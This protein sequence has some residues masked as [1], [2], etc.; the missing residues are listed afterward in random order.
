MLLLKFVEIGIGSANY[1]HYKKLGYKIPMHYNKLKKKYQFI[2]GAK[3]KVKIED[4]LISRVYVDVK[5]DNCGKVSKILYQGYLNNKHEDG[6]DYCLKCACSIFNGGENSYRWNP[7]L[8]EEQR[9]KNDSRIGSVE[10]YYEFIRKV[11]KR[12]SYK[13]V[14]CGSKKDIHVHHL[15]GFS[16][17]IKNQTNPENAVCL[18]GK[19]HDKFHAIY[20]KDNNT[21]EQFEEFSNNKNINLVC[22]SELSSL[23]KVVLLNNGKIYNTAKECANE[24]NVDVKRI[25]DVCHHKAYTV[26]DYHFMYLDEY[27]NTP[28]EKL[29][30]AHTYQGHNS[31]GKGVGKCVICVNTGE[32]FN[33]IS[34]A[35][36]KYLGKSKND[37]RIAKCCNGE[38]EFVGKLP[39]GEKIKWKW[40]LK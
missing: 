23:K 25:Y 5:C 6:K 26:N 38:L 24:L 27:L 40:D 21:K 36:K 8:T 37:G 31:H 11:Q 1:K 17:D 9:S 2:K 15:N 18:C 29:K 7:N 19:C 32:K 4:I 39:S 3:I 14:I 30:D 20:G 35:Y 13:C 12:D 10:G 22:S 16:W 34:D 28:K 33:S